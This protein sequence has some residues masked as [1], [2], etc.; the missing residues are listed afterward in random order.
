[1]TGVQT[2]AL[3]ISAKRAL[4]T[5][6]NLDQKKLVDAGEVQRVKDEAIAAVKSQFEPVVSERDQLRAE[7]HRE[8]VGGAFA[9]SKFVGEKLAI[10]V[11][12][13]ESYFGSRFKLEDGKVV[14]FDASGNKIFSRIN[15]GAPA[16][17]E[18]A[19]EMMVDA[20]PHRDHILKG[21][22]KGGGGSSNPNT[23]PTGAKTIRA[24]EFDKL[25]GIERAAKMAEGYMLV[26]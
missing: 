26:D 10:P 13:V 6:A 16:E 19:L 14:A 25:S 11:D 9:R 5:L 2:C 17:F 12:L 24:A 20:Y 8:K 22:I 23:P 4:E 3:P 7:L 18:E 15:P 1:V 21:D